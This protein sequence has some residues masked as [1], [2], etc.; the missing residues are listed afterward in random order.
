M[1]D[2]LSRKVRFVKASLDEKADVTRAS[3][4]LE[5]GGAERF[6]GRVERPSEGVNILQA[7]AQAAAE[8]VQQAVGIEGAVISVQDVTKT[9]VFGEPVVVVSVSATVRNETFQL[10]GVCH[11]TDD[12]AEAAALAVLNATNRV[13]DLA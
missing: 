5:R 6:V 13:C 12:L 2:W 10:Y 4:E 3:V 1:K 11:V 7:G 8:A 9:L